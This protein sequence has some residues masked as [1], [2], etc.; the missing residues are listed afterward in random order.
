MHSRLNLPKCKLNV[1]SR[2]L[3]RERWM[4]KNPFLASTFE[5]IVELINLPVS[6][7]FQYWC[8]AVSNFLLRSFGSRQTQWAI[9]VGI[10][11]GIHLGH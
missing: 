5:Q 1:V 11:Y 7:F 10:F 3:S 4:L 9:L 2:E 6:Y 8:F